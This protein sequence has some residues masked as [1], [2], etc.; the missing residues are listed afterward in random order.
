MK[1]GTKR[2][3]AGASAEA[4]G[5]GAAGAEGSLRGGERSEEGC[6]W[7]RGWAAAGRGASSRGCRPW[8]DAQGGALTGRQP[9][10]Q[11]ASNPWPAHC[12]APALA[13]QRCSAGS[14]AGTR[15]RGG[16]APNSHA[17]G[18][19]HGQCLLLWGEEL[20]GGSAHGF[21]LGRQAMQSCSL[22]TGR[23]GRPWRRGRRA[24]VGQAG[25]GIWPDGHA[26]GAG[27][28]AAAAGPLGCRLLPKV[29]AAAGSS[30]RCRKEQR[31][32]GRLRF[33]GC[34]GLG[35][36]GRALAGTR[37]AGSDARDAET[38]PS[39]PPYQACPT[40]ACIAGSSAHRS[41]Q[42]RRRQR[43]RQWRLWTGRWQG[44]AEGRAARE[45]EGRRLGE[46]GG[47]GAGL[48]GAG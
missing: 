10:C 37:R 27:K 16:C 46:A 25:L 21:G 1:S 3:G 7:A 33:A 24:A 8:T 43:C 20:W 39:L 28:A 45:G 5:V 29:E 38:V 13:S 19:S 23:R 41:R 47:R 31:S 12:P 14:R 48:E 44:T 6:R 30:C 11:A 35:Q 42:R 40:C 9:V 18:G 32:G 34:A 36:Q 17:V 15:R 22:G 4:S 26:L 2:L